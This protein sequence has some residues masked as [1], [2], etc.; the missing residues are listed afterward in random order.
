MQVETAGVSGGRS[1]SGE[2][3]CAGLGRRPRRQPRAG[4]ALELALHFRSRVRERTSALG[5]L[6]KDGSFTTVR[7]EVY[8]SYPWLQAI[9]VEDVLRIS[10]SE[11]GPKGFPDRVP[12]EPDRGGDRLADYG[13]PVSTDNPKCF[14]R[15]VPVL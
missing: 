12:L 3:I 1:R 13:S 15:A 7:I 11:N 10:C 4:P 14:G 9:L 8:V 2:Q 6:L 5:L